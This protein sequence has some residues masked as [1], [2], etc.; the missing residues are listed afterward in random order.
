MV[1]VKENTF[2]KFCH[3]HDEKFP[4]LSSILAK[5]KQQKI[6]RYVLTFDRIVILLNLILLILIPIKGCY[7]FANKTSIFCFHRDKLK[8]IWR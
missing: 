6:T 1:S 7:Y 5:E 4:Q 8:I 3:T 2:T